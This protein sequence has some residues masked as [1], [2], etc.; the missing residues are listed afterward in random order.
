MSLVLAYDQANVN[1]LA[2]GVANL[3]AGATLIKAKLSCYTW[4]PSDIAGNITQGAPPNTLLGIAYVAHGTAIP[5]VTTANWKTSTF[6]IAGPGKLL[7]Y[8]R[9]AIN[10]E[11]ADSAHVFV[12]HTYSN[13]IEIDFPFFNAAAFDLGISINWLGAGFWSNGLAWLSYQ[14]EAWFD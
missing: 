2:T 11:P 13:E 1:S 14:F 4:F 3:P 8:D 9:W 7:A 5:V 10:G 12:Q 6:I